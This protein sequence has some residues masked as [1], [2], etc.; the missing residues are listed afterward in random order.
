MK[1]ILVTGTAG[2]I[3]FHLAELLLGEGHQVHGYDGMTDYYDVA[4]KR[5]RHQLLLQNSNFACT[6]ALLENFATLER[7]AME[8]RP[9]VIVHL[10]AQAGV[11]HSLTHPQSFVTSNLVGFANVLEA[12]RSHLPRHLVF[13][14]SSSV[15]GTSAKLPF[16]EDDPAA[17][18]ISPYAATK[19]A[20]E[21]LC[22][23][24]HALYSLPVTCLR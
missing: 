7:V 4:L 14:S 15:Y 5:R 8:F 17:R 13:A 6:E 18:P 24:Y 21:L 2:F 12:C 11:R 9:D 23:T 16:R 3:G 22:H 19:R 20:G 10:A 1:R